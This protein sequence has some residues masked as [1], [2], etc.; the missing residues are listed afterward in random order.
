MS[1]TSLA[2]SSGSIFVF[3]L[4]TALTPVTFSDLV[5]V[6]SNPWVL[7]T[8]IVIVAWYGSKFVT[9]RIRPR[10][11]DR[12][13]T[14]T[15]NL[16]LVAFRIAVVFYAFVPFA[17]LLG[18]RPQNVLLSFT[19]LSL[20]LGAILAPVGRS[21]ISG[22]FIVY[23][24][25]YEVGD[26]IELVEREE[27]GY[28]EEIT[29][30]YTKVSTLENSF[31]VI[32]NESMRERD[33]RNLS[34]DGERIRATITVDIT[35]ESDLDEACRL[36]EEAA[37]SVDGVITDESTIR[38]G[39]SRFPADPKALVDE[40]ADH[41][42]R[43]VLK[44]WVEE[45]YLPAAIRSDVQR[46]AWDAFENADVEIAYPHTH[47]VFDETSGRAKIDLDS[48]DFDRN[49]DADRSAARDDP[50]EVDSR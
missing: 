43:V 48:R 23:N 36:L 42:I 41:G 44:F 33:I 25:P 30:G 27:R 35:Y 40:F 2:V 3:D 19:V 4:T 13:R 8:L 15:T 46:T 10:L 39:R 18:F 1:L 7:A 17:G 14:S 16:L 20:I 50:S 45:P 11:E 49:G 5:A 22:L 31:L 37:R 38:V 29:L 34:A 47:V 24:R 6:L 9:N 28:V 21:Y 12:L 32:P 26:M